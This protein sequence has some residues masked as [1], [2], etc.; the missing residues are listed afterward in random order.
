MP[1]DTHGVLDRCSEC[2]ERA[3]IKETL[4]Q[5]TECPNAVQYQG[6]HVDAMVTWNQAQR[7]TKAESKRIP[8]NSLQA[9]DQGLLRMGWRGGQR[10]AG[11]RVVL[12]D[13][14]VTWMPEEATPAV[15]KAVKDV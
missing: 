11:F 10:V 12:S 5:C 2:G 8:M 6:D 15:R 1:V 13:G 9:Q 4:V 7:K 3:E 14:R